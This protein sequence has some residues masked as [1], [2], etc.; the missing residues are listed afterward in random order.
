MGI[1]PISQP[2]L[3]CPHELKQPHVS[4]EMEEFDESVAKKLGSHILNNKDLLE[5]IA[6]Y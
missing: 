5:S 6:S 2:T 4:K 1:K 3:Q